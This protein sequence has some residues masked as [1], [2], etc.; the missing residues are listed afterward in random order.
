M[1]HLSTDPNTKRSWPCHGHRHQRGHRIIASQQTS[2]TAGGHGGVA[3]HQQ[4]RQRCTWRTVALTDGA[5]LNPSTFL[6]ASAG[7]KFQGAG[8][9]SIFQNMDPADPERAKT[10]RAANPSF[11]IQNLELHII[12]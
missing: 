1:C 11:H 12:R 8:S 3:G 9:A 10:Q 2:T 4:Q 6:V 5:T 7:V